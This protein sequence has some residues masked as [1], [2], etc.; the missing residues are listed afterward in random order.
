MAALCHEDIFMAHN[1]AGR[2]ADRNK[3]LAPLTPTPS[4]LCL[5]D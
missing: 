1:R 4:P 2:L 5:D 3:L